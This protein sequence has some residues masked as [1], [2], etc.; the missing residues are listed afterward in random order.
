M[1]EKEISET[2]YHDP[3]DYTE[4]GKRISDGISFRDVIKDMLLMQGKTL[5]LI[6]KWILIVNM[7]MS[8][9]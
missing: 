6:S 2:Y 3:N 7:C 4:N 9:Q 5:R 1:I 8:T